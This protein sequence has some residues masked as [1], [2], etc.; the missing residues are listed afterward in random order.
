[1]VRSGN[2]GEIMEDVFNIRNFNVINDDEN[3]YFFRALNLADNND[4]ETGIIADKDGNVERIRTD[5]ERYIE[6]EKAK[7]SQDS[8]IS[9]EQ[10]YDHIK[11]HYRKDTNCIS[12]SSNANISIKYGRERYKDKY[13]LVKVPKK[14]FGIKVINAGVYMLQ[15][16]EKR[17]NEYLNSTE[18]DDNLR[19]TLE[20]IENCKTSKKLKEIIKKKYTSNKPLDL[21][22][23]GI[24]KEIKFR[25]PSV[26]ISDYKTLNNEQSL[27]T[28]KIVARLTLLERNKKMKTIISHT[29]NNNDLIRTIGR[30]FSSLEFIHYGE[31]K[32]GEIINI[33][34]E[35]VDKFTL[36][37][38]L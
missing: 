35:V 21:Y 3:Y 32:K 38:Q 19:K 33:S 34:K 20:K 1:M 28:N 37:Q 7:Y 9:L 31:I 16:I 14:E 26:R 6:N 25:T 17:V 23:A 5:R 24:R 2:K 30:A 27:K 18:I 12:L 22:K 11:V 4:L 36:I 29:A 10:V 15:E 8:P 13:I